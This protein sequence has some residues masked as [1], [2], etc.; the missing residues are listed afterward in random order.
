MST[1]GIPFVILLNEILSKLNEAIYV[2]D[3]E[4]SNELLKRVE[5]ILE[6][7]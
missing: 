1:L 7:M 6:N 4:Y 5:L 3:K 2:F